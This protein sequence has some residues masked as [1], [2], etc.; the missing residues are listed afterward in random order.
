MEARRFEDMCDNSGPSGGYRALVQWNAPC[1]CEANLAFVTSHLSSITVPPRRALKPRKTPTQARSKATVEA[2]CRAAAQ[3]LQT[4]GYAGATTD[5]IAKRAGVS[6]GSLYQYFPN[7]DA[8]LVALVERHI[9]EGFAL[10]H[11]LVADALHKPSTM[12]SFLRHVVD[13]MIAVH[14][15]EPRLHR[16][17]FEEAPLPASVRTD[18]RRRENALTIELRGL[19][20]TFPEVTTRDAGV[21]AYVTMHTIDALVHDFVLR[22]PDGIDTSQLKEELVR[23]LHRHLTGTVA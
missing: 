13:A 6:V 3:V 12:V 9:A 20:E 7:K 21:T 5:K 14:E 15:K 19:L 4:Q 11:E 8:L 2:I 1:K 18:I 17:L 22:P 23:M 16:V 10:V